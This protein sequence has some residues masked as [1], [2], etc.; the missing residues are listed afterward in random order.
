MGNGQNTFC[1]KHSWLNPHAISQDK[2]KMLAD[3]EYMADQ[4]EINDF[5]DNKSFSK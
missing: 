5:E 3:L 4:S 2:L 1:C